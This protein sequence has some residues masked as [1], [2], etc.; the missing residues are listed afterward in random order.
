MYTDA[1]DTGYGGYVVKHGDCV[2]YGQ[3][4]CQEAGHSS[5][6]HELSAVW[7]VLQAVAE[8]LLNCYLDGLLITVVR[9]LQVGSR[10]LSCMLLP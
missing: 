4:T 5:T 3:W 8:K 7:L 9:S 2:S 10:S 1:S 6:W